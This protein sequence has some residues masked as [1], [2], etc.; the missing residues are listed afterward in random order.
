MRQAL[1]YWG[2]SSLVRT[3]PISLSFSN[4][5]IGQV[6]IGHFL[7]VLIHVRS[8]V[9]DDWLCICL[10]RYLIR[11]LWCHKF[12][13]IQWNWLASFTS[14]R[15]YNVIYIYTRVYIIYIYIYNIISRLVVSLKCF[16][17]LRVD[18]ELQK[19]TASWSKREIRIEK[20][21]TKHV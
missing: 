20:P 4:P 3:S 7:R 11:Y 12:A 14:G 18:I 6:G 10:T 17:L 8:W 1:Y 2:V 5:W 19:S 9:W 15:W 16:R 21:A 13:A